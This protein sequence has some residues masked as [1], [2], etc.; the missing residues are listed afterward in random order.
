METISC[1]HNCNQTLHY[2]T[3]LT[4]WTMMRELVKSIP[5]YSL[6]LCRVIR[7]KNA[8]SE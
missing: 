6:T 4:A 7:R 1:L 3:L 5:L 2:T 8:I